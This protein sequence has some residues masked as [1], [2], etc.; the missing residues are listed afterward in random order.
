M[1][2]RKRRVNDNKEFLPRLWTEEEDVLL[3]KLSERSPDKEIS[4]KLDRTISAIHNRR[5]ILREKGII[6]D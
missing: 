5:Y 4:E 3:I 2:E 6:E 1:A